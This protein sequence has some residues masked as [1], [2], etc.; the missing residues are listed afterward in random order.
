MYTLGHVGTALL[1]YAPVAALFTAAGEPALAATGV[2][3]AVFVCTLPDIDNELEIDHRGPTHTIWFACGCGL[4][5]ALVGALLPSISATPAVLETGSGTADLAVVVGTATLL[6]VCSHL[7]A[8]S[9]T[10][11][12][13]APFAPVSRWHHTFDV[14][15]ARNQRANVALLAAGVAAAS[16]PQA[17]LLA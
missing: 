5:G 1:V 7:L 16:G 4:V 8:D 13:I 14:V 9:I 6:G 10:P 2:A 3:A 12:G 11:M 15:P 17:V